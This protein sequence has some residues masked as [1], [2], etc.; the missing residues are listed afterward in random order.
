MESKYFPAKPESTSIKDKQICESISLKDNAP[1]SDAP[2]VPISVNIPK[3]IKRLN[4]FFIIFTSF[5]FISFVCYGYIIKC[6]VS[7]KTDN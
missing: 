2:I 5:R 4:K 3:A 7:K 6:N 1:T